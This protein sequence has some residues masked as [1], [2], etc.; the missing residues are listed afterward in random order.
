MIHQGGIE[1]R[2]QKPIATHIK[3]TSWLTGFQHV[4]TYKLGCEW[5]HLLIIAALEVSNFMEHLKNLEQ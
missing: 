1:I 4:I 2:G 5:N 3:F